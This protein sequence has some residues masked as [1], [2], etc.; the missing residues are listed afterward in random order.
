VVHP[1]RAEAEKHW[2]EFQK[3]PEW[4]KVRAESEVNGALVNHVES[5][6]MSPTDFSALR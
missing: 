1:S 4:V 5:V 3:D 6:F 2:A